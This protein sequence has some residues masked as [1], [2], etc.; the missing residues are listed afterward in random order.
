MNLKQNQKAKVAQVANS[1]EAASGLPAAAPVEQGGSVADAKPTGLRIMSS[2]LEDARRAQRL[3]PSSETEANIRSAVAYL[4]QSAA[5]TS[6]YVPCVLTGR[7]IKLEPVALKGV[8]EVGGID[9]STCRTYRE[10][11]WG[12]GHFRAALVDDHTPMNPRDGDNLTTLSLWSRDY[13]GDKEHQILPHQF[14]GPQAVYESIKAKIGDGII[15]PVYI[16]EHSDI[17]FKLGKFTGPDAQWDSRPAGFMFVSME[18][19]REEYGVEVLDDEIREKVLEA[20]KGELQDYEDYVRCNAYGFVVDAGQGSVQVESCYG[21]LGDPADSDVETEAHA[22]LQR[23]YDAWAEERGVRVLLDD[24]I[25][26]GGV[27]KAVV[28]VSVEGGDQYRVA[29]LNPEPGVCQ[30]QVSHD[31]PPEARDDNDGFTVTLESRDLTPENLV[32]LGIG[33]AQKVAALLVGGQSLEEL[34]PE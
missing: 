33:E 12:L 23:A 5:S 13:E 10:A 17:A 7:P 18:T 26:P 21:F 9:V 8:D 2:L 22:A 15:L 29:V 20:M 14:E 32:A 34:M 28:G 3:A 19:I 11:V 31:V 25:E 6:S 27:V 16:Y 24:E 4:G 30:V 1:S